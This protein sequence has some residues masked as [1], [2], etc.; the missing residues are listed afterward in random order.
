MRENLM[1][2]EEEL[3]QTGADIKVVERENLHFTVKFLGE[4]PESIVEEIDKRLRTLVLQ[5]MEV[6]VRGVGAFP[7]AR[8]P[9]VVWAGV[10]PRTSPRSRAP[11][12][13]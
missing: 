9:R 8:R 6:A 2:V 7:D 1:K 11:G 12:S 13:G 4:I 10:S 3:K 5:R